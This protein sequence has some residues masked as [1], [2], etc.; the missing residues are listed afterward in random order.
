MGLNS[1]SAF[2]VSAQ[3]LY[4][5]YIRNLQCWMRYREICVIPIISAH[6]LLLDSIFMHRMLNLKEV[7]SFIKHECKIFAVS[8]FLT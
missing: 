2:S 1:S 7:I 5:I 8:N 6:V 4:Q 3:V